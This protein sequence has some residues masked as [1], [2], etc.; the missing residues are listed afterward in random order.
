MSFPLALQQRFLQ[1]GPFA[2]FNAQH[3]GEF[4]M[5]GTFPMG[6]R[7][8]DPSYQ[9][10]NHDPEV[11][12]TDPLISTETTVVEPATAETLNRIQVPEGVTPKKAMCKRYVEEI[13]KGRAA[14]SLGEE[15]PEQRSVTDAETINQIARMAQL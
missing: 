9:I 14:T 11:N 3:L 4:T 13:A 15:V 2:Q 8:S 10:F 7:L 6:Q 1:S 5:P 12:S